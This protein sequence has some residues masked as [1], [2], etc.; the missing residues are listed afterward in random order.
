MGLLSYYLLIYFY[1]KSFYFF[2]QQQPEM[3]FPL[4][5]IFIRNSKPRARGV[6]NILNIALNKLRN[7]PQALTNIFLDKASYTN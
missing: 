2:C 3:W 7:L 5:A 4:D 1:F 6:N